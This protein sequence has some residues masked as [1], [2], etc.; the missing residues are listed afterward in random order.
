MTPP[1]Y[2]PPAERSVAAL[3]AKAGR[4]VQEFVYDLMLENDGRTI[5]YRPIINYSDG[6][7]EAVATMMRHPNTVLGLGDG[8]AHVSIICDSAAPTY[9]ISH[10][11]RDRDR[12]AKM[13]LGWIIKRL[14]R[15]PAEAIGLFDRGLLEPGMKADI[16]VIDHDTIR[17]HPPEVRYDLPAGG[18]R[19]VQR[20]DGYVATIVSG[21]PVRMGGTS[22]GELPGRLVRGMQEG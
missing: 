15:D 17:L 6:D 8:G 10:W 13:D 3:A 22:T 4:P 12:G 11:T 20:S 21:T 5:L 7:L 18:R 16:N 14:T 1:D 9:T 2:E 19:L